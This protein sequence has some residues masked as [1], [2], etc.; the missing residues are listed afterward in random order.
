MHL[1]EIANDW[2]TNRS[3]LSFESGLN[4]QSGHSEG[5]ASAPM[6]VLADALARVFFCRRASEFCRVCAHFQKVAYSHCAH[7]HRLYGAN[8]TSPSEMHA[9]PSA[10]TNA[11]N[12]R[13]QGGFTSSQQ[14]R[15]TSCKFPRG[16]ANAMNLPDNLLGT[17]K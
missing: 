16:P 6:P 11:V 9:W 3:T 15:S 14:S 17:G 4:A 13:S 7:F 2:V 5:L 12:L 8:C 10:L 1:T